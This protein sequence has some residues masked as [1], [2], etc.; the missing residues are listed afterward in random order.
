MDLEGEELWSELIR[1]LEKELKVKQE[2]SN[3]KKKSASNERTEKSTYC[4]SS[5]SNA[6]ETDQECEKS[7]HVTVGNQSAGT[8]KCAFC[9]E[10]GHF[11]R[12]NVNG[13]KVVDDFSCEKF[14]QMTPLDRFNELRRKGLCYMCLYPGA[15]H[16]L[17]NHANGS[18]Q[19]EFTCRHSSHNSYKKKKH[20]LV[21]HEHK[22]EEQNKKTLENYKNRFILNRPNVPDFA[23]D[24]KLS[25]MS[26]QAFISEPY[27]QSKSINDDS[28]VTEN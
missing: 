4:A 5:N 25:F 13:N 9:D 27:D 22:N 3:I 20:V 21:C 16:H 15:L 2:L 23:K 17:G 7:V 1:F 24:I 28:I 10:T 8:T 18:C 26:K 19:S 11:E 14:V 6:D 12:T